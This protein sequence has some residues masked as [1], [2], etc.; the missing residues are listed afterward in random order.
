MNIPLLLKIILTEKLKSLNN[1]H[2]PLSAMTSKTCLRT[3][4]DVQKS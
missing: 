1:I 2:K 4:Q 3:L